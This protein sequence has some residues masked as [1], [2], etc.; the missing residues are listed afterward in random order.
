M[1]RNPQEMNFAYRAGWIFFRVCFASYFR[2]R[3]FNPER[4]PATGPVIVASN[5]ASYLDPPFVGTGCRRLLI[6]LA[7]KSLF[8]FPIFGPLLRSWNAIPVDPKGGSAAGL[9]GILDRLLEGFAI[10]IFPEGTRCRDGKLGPARSGV[11]MA[12]IKSSAPVVPVRIWGSY[13]AYG[14]NH[15]FPLPRRIMIKY[16][17]PLMFEIE[18][19]EAKSCSKQRL[20]AIYQEVADKVMKAIAALEPCEDRDGIP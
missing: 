19:E 4:V 2:W 15:A 7:R 9:K 8:R 5:H 1:A 6:M 13:E 18:R 10:L 14:R 16:G 17:R 11:G 3:I 12:V 20:K